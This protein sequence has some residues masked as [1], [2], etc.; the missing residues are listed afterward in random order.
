MIGPNL[1]PL[2]LK[3]SLLGRQAVHPQ[4]ILS[5]RVSAE[6]R[7]ERHSTRPTYDC[8]RA[9]RKPPALRDWGSSESVLA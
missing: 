3:I 8:A 1:R 7:H 4:G 9:E 6:S 5:V 2:T